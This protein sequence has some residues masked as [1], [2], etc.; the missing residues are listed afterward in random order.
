M[1]FTVLQCVNIDIIINYY[2][3]K[4]HCMYQY[5]FKVNNTECAKMIKLPK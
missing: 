3:D 5:V 1:P 2:I 4:D